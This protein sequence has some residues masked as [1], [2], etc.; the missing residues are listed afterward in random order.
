[1]EKR[2]T[3]FLIFIALLTGCLQTASPATV[4]ST[5]SLTLPTPTEVPPLPTFEPSPAATDI[6]P[7]LAGTPIPLAKTVITAKN[8]VQIKMIARWG[9]GGA[10]QMQ[11]SQDKSF[12]ASLSSFGLKFLNPETFE[13][14]DQLYFDD[15][16]IQ[17]FELSPDNR[18]IALSSD[19][20]WVMLWDKPS[21]RVIRKWED[22]TTVSKD[23]SMH[24]SPD[25]AT[26]AT[27]H[28]SNIDIW[29]TKSGELLVRVDRGNQESVYALVYVDN[30]TI[31][32]TTS[33]SV[34]RNSY[35]P[36]IQLWS[37]KSPDSK[38]IKLKG[39][40]KLAFSNLA[41]SPDGRT[42]VSDTFDGTIS[43]WDLKTN[44]LK[45]SFRRQER[46]RRPITFAEDGAKVL[47][48]N[49]D[50]TIS[51]FDVNGR[52]I[53]RFEGTESIVGLG[54]LPDLT[55]IVYQTDRGTLIK[56]EI[57]TGKLI[58]EKMGSI[59]LPVTSDIS[60]D[61]HSLALGFVGGHVEIW[62]IDNANLETVIPHENL[63]GYAPLVK[64]SFNGKILITG[65][66]DQTV[67]VW[68]IEDGNLI[69]TLR[70]KGYASSIAV[71]SDDEL[72][73]GGFADNTFIWETSS[74]ELYRKLP[75]ADGIAFSQDNKILAL[76][77]S[78]L[79]FFDIESGQS[80]RW[81]F[82]KSSTS[83]TLKDPVF[84]P[85]GN[86]IAGIDFM[87]SFNS[88]VVN[89]EKDSIKIWRVEDGSLV[90]EIEGL[91]NPVSLTF[92]P[93]GSL[94]MF[95]MQ[96]RILL[97]DVTTFTLK[98]ELIGHNGEILS[99]LFSDDGKKIVTT[100]KDQTV[101]IWAVPSP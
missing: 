97:Y 85:N 9:D 76:G 36:A 34:S 69:R 24:F 8:A 2:L 12:I 14:I 57:N 38:R 62:N 80:L 26:L 13:I 56:R 51:I 23:V 75:N 74:G 25:G 6:P 43:F 28:G 29:D 30:V 82:G 91:Y 42:L 96:N 60:T 77:G 46:S 88:A 18:T 17:R 84:S 40:T 67:K 5:P 19:Q 1:M 81:I 52:L 7:S 3:V 98:E 101:G 53:N 54:V 100:S 78:G 35:I 71:S 90:N 49:L 20:G 87:W 72:I 39:N 4:I 70:G 15:F 27:Y 86:L 63:V 59:G 22:S 64:F 92:S 58:F 41:V 99:V 21:K 47:I 48:P 94:L 31:A 50:G 95:A 37:F 65:S 66:Y 33:P 93:D 89:P 10:R 73:V 44:T 45:S 32:Y 83:S 79:G 55:T 68:N 11:I 61:G 16:N